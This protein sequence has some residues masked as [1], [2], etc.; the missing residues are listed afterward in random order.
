MMDVYRALD[1]SRFS[2]DFLIMDEGEQYFE[3]EVLDIGGDIYRLPP[4]RKSGA[5]K[6][7]LAMY[8]IIR[9]GG[10]DAV[11]AHTSFHCGPAMLAACMAGVK[12]RISHARTSGTRIGSL[13]NRLS[14]GAGRLLIAAFSTDRLAI[15]R[16]A[17]EYLFGK[18]P[19]RILPNAIDYKKYQNVPSETVETLK[20]EF[21]IP[22]GVNVIGMVGR[23]NR[24]KNHEFALKWFEAYIKEEPRSVLAFIGEGA[25]LREI[26]AKAED[27]VPGGRVIFAGIRKDID[28]W[29][30]MFGAL[31]VPSLF[32]GLGGVILEAQAAGTP[33]VKSDMFNNE[34]DLGIGLVRE[35]P[36][37]EP[38]SRWS[39][40][41]DGLMALERPSAERI[42]EAFERKGYS[43]GAELEVLYG[44]YVGGVK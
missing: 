6:N 29:M 8:R 5:V 20:K 1:K 26:K 24:M 36:P 39:E 37:T 18:K 23:F 38:L 27:A 14:L 43:I 25:L 3:K 42:A 19:F 13:K 11:H 32:E 40:A 22:S 33:V 15:S 7:L 35:L 2:F 31:I 28:V 44:I 9:D 10:Y 34:A 21:S 16:E 41:V 4:P 30:N 17:G 12:I